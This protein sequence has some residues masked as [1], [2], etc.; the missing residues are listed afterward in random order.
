MILVIIRMKV[1]SEK[2]PALS[3]TIALENHYVG[4][5]FSADVC[6]YLEDVR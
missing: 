2:R 3:Q 4:N 1:P 5:G 6:I